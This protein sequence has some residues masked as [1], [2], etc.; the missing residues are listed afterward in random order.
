MKYVNT[1]A[2]TIKK[3]MKNL[4]IN[5]AEIKKNQILKLNS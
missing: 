4:K 3:I 2:N 5:L 1:T